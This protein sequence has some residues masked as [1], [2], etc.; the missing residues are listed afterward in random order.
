VLEGCCRGD[1][2][3]WHAFVLGTSRSIS[4]YVLRALRSSPAAEVNL[5][6]IA[7][8]TQEVYV[9]CLADGCRTLREFRGDTEQALF[10]Y[11]ARI[12]HSVTADHGRRQRSR[13]RYAHL[14]TLSGPS[15]EEGEGA[16]L[17]DVLPAPER[18]GPDRLYEE[19]ELIER[20]DEFLASVMTGRNRHRDALIFKL[21]VLEGL[22]AREIAALPA[23]RM[24]CKKVEAIIHRTRERLRVRLAPERM[25]EM[26]R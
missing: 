21:H 23:F 5:S 24:N 1:A 7:D 3:A 22:T 8:L 14:V 17:L 19:R 10:A 18:N 11:L 20:G 2:D 12:A 16:G 25:Q 26:N 13:K 4:R 9:R 15:S 6:E